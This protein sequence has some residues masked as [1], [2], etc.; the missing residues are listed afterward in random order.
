MNAS[1]GKNFAWIQ[2]IRFSEYFKQFLELYAFY[3]KFLIDKIAVV[4]KGPVIIYVER[5]RE[6]YV[7]KI[8]ISV[9]PP[10]QTM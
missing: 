4:V 3:T 6:K 1:E 8:K 10:L 2:R 5:G 7:Q 9:R